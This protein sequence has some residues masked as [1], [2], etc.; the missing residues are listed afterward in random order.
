MGTISRP[1]RSR[2]NSGRGMV[3]FRGRDREAADKKD[4]KVNQ[5]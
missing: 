5:N 2:H 1:G 4:D 3:Q